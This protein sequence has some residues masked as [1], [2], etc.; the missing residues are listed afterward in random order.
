MRPRS[1]VL[2]TLYGPSIYVIATQ[3]LTRLNSAETNKSRGEATSVHTH[4]ST[5]MVRKCVIERFLSTDIDVGEGRLRD[6]ENEY[7]GQQYYALAL[8]KK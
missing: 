2:L 8:V 7:M 6:G 1:A 3:G 4:V 5:S